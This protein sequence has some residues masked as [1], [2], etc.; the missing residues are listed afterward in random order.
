MTD[1]N[2]Y[3]RSR[4]PLYIQAA[5]QMRLKIERGIWAPGSQLPVIED[6]QAELDLSRATVRE[7][8]EMLE[9]EGLIERYR[10]RG[11]FVRAAL[12]ERRSHDLPTTWDGLLAS[13]R[14]I[15][16]KLVAPMDRRPGTS[17]QGVLAGS[18]EGEFVW[19]QRVHT[20]ADEPYCL[21]DINLREDVYEL[22]AER[23]ASVPVVLVLAERHAELVEEVRQR[24]L[25]SNADE[26]SA[27]ALGIA[28]GAPVVEIMRTLIDRNDQVIAHTYARY[29]GEYVR[30][31]VQFA[32]NNKKPGRSSGRNECNDWQS[33]DGDCS[34]S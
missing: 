2:L 26:T 24:I 12:P 6:L 14:N 5:G 20:R 13:L 16:P 10:G 19:F 34:P 8:L 29:P 33:S 7:A 17:L 23:F 28:L 18:A 9:E 4:Q 1:T 21:I 31:D 25:F 30:I 11:T 15:K 32:L 3:I 22:D 27:R